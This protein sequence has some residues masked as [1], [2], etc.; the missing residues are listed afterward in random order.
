M[1]LPSFVEIRNKALELGW[2][3]MAIT[4]AKIPEEDIQAYHKWIEKEHHGSMSYMENALRCNPDQLLPGAKTAILFISYYKQK[5]QEFREDA[6]LIASYARGRDYHNVHHRRLKR[7][8][9]W[10]EERTGKS[11]IAKGFSDSTPILEKALAV[12]AGL[13]WFGKNT[14]LIHRKF[15]TFTLLSGCL[16]TLELEISK[17][18]ME[19]RLPRCG[20]CTK[21]LDACPTGALVNPYELDATKCLSYHLI[22]SKKKIPLEIQKKNPGYVF[23]CDIC[24]D[25]CPHNARKAESHSEDFKPQREFLRMDDVKYFIAKPES[26]F[27]TPLKRRGAI[28]LQETLKSLK[29][30]G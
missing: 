14:L 2:D 3:D 23:G 26:L 17:P 21:C 6:G 24:Q 20:S 27:G 25:V 13:G 30:E 7:F 22:E 10:L 11:E 29:D 8:I 1:S 5:P 28:G 12:Q 9:R 18:T 19:M 16:T 4:H 15:G